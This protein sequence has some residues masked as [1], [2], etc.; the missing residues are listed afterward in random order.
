MSKFHM[1]YRLWAIIGLGFNPIGELWHKA[2]VGI[3]ESL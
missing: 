1:P 3:Y 2:P